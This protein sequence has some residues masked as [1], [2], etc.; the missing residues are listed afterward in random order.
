MTL[1][2][3][4]FLA[5]AVGVLGLAPTAAATTTTTEVVQFPITH[6]IYNTCNNDIVLIVGTTQVQLHITATDGGKLLFE[7]SDWV[8]DYEA[9]STLTGQRYVYNEEYGDVTQTYQN[10]GL[11]SRLRDAINLIQVGE[12]GSVVNDDL[13]VHFTFTVRVDADG[14]YTTE[15]NFDVDCH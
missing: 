1:R 9:S 5:T 13:H 12:D 3:R 4:A 10:G 2:T 15:E 11:V 14:N 6:T 7:T 8:K